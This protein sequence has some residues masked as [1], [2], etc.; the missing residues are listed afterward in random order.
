M[1]NRRIVLLLAVACVCACGKGAY[2]QEEEEHGHADIL[3]AVDA[4]NPDRLITGF[5]F[6]DD[7]EFETGARIFEV[8]LEPTTDFPNVTNNLF[9]GD[10]GFFTPASDSGDL[11]PGTL[12]LPAGDMTLIIKAFDIGGTVAN[13]WFWDLSGPDVDFNP[14]ADGNT[15]TLDNNPFFLTADGSSSDVTTGGPSNLPFLLQTVGQN[16]ALHTHADIRVDDLS[17]DALPPGGIYLLALEASIN[18]TSDPFFMLLN[19]AGELGEDFIED[20]EEFVE[21]NLLGG[22]TAIPEPTSIALLVG[23]AGVAA[24][25]RNKRTNA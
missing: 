13:G 22:G 2:G 17:G 12:P 8:D 6:V 9:L 23:M 3:V 20:A 7:G 11:P 1:L 15:I 25:R 24:R 19:T 14:L 21:L 16:G 5:S 4:A 10:Q 18:P